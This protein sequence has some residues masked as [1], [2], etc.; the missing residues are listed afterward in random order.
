VCG[1]AGVSRHPH[2]A[3]MYVRVGAAVTGYNVDYVELVWESWHFGV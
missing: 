2:T 1:S 3:L